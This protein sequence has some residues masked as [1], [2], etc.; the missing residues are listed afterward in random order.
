MDIQVPTNKPKGFSRSCNPLEVLLKLNY[1]S[2]LATMSKRTSNAFYA[3]SRT[4]YT[5]QY[6]SSST[7]HLTVS[8]LP[9]K[10]ARTQ[11][12][13]SKSTPRLIAAANGSN[14]F[15]Q[16]QDSILILRKG[17]SKL[18]TINRKGTI[19]FIISSRSFIENYFEIEIVVTDH[20]PITQK[21][22]Q[23]LSI[24]ATRVLQIGNFFSSSLLLNYRLSQ[25]I[26]STKTPNI[27]PGTPKRLT[28][29]HNSKYPT[30]YLR[31]L[32]SSIE[33]DQIMIHLS[34]RTRKG[35]KIASGLHKD[36]QLQ[37]DKITS[38]IEI[39]E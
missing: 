8:H 23:Q 4:F 21:L 30:D 37:K 36:N 12:H 27:S 17:I 2:S 34:P 18:Y 1:R 33:P 22:V 19:G 35:L 39:S 9:A 5:C 20:I 14:S 29:G 6:N 10:P 25:G 11:I 31:V 15:N 26:A 13:F 24:I 38:R 32:Y 28:M 16:L 3:T 7:D